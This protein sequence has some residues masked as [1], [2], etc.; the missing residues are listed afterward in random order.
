MEYKS[1]F[2][3]VGTTSFDELFYVVNTK[4]T[5]EALKLL[6]CKK[7][8]M[9]YG[10]GEPIKLHQELFE[11]ITVELYGLKNGISADIE[12][13]DLVI[14][15]AGAGTCLEVLKAGKPLIVVVN[16]SLMDNHQGEL[17]RAMASQGIVMSCTVTTLSKTLT[18]FNGQKLKKL[19]PGHPELFQ[20]QLDRL[21]GYF[22]V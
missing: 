9:Q 19:S 8:V 17:S 5:V 4:Q 12:A 11:G 3:T 14:G 20:E 6:G 1:V 15:H 10:R 7:V 21:M 22:S 13:A 2:I 18:A 16:D